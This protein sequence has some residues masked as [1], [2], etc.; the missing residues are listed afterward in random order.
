M[1]AATKYTEKS[2]ASSTD[3]GVIHAPRLTV[4]ADIHAV[5][6]FHSRGSLA[7]NERIED[8][9]GLSRET[10]QMLPTRTAALAVLIGGDRPNCVQLIE[11]D[12]R[13]IWTSPAIVP[14][15][16]DAQVQ[17]TGDVKIYVDKRDWFQMFLLRN[18]LKDRDLLRS[19][20]GITVSNID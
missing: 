12:G 2:F 19:M 5:M 18:S 17:M 7:E 1:S 8:F 15:S 14:V 16:A 6:L 11:C 20:F 3:T 10:F 9:I 13:T 4:K